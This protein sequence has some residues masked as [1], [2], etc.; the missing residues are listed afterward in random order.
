[1]NIDQISGA[2]KDFAGKVQEQFGKMLGSKSQQ[3]K[4]VQ[5]QGAGRSDKLSGSARTL[6]SKSIKKRRAILAASA[7]NQETH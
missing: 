4:G 7:I 3:V 1:M 5:L 2:G 6:I